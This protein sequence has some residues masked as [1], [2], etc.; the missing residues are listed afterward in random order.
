VLVR[1]AQTVHN[2]L[3]APQPRVLLSRNDFNEYFDVCWPIT[4][5]RLRISQTATSTMAWTAAVSRFIR[6]DAS[7]TAV[8][9]V[10]IH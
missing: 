2:E 4:C 7:D 5:G 1:I 6:R 9:L 3:I 8:E 10:R